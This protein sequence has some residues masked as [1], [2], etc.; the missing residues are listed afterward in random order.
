[1]A[2]CCTRVMYVLP[3]CLGRGPF[4][5]NGLFHYYEPLAKSLQLL[6]LSLV[7]FL[8]ASHYNRKAIAASFL[9]FAHRTRNLLETLGNM[10]HSMDFAIECPPIDAPVQYSF[11]GF[12]FS[13]VR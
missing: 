8:S 6:S 7:L 12:H 11:R 13:S 1:M 4:V 9:E 5:Y 10:M 2:G 3:H